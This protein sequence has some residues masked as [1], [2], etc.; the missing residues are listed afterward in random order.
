MG[1]GTETEGTT[2]DVF[3]SYTRAE[4]ADARRLIA[5]LEQ[6]GFSVWWDGML[7][8][9]TVFTRTTEQALDQAKAVVV[10]WS[11]KSVHS[12]WVRDEAQAGRETGRLVPVSFDGTLPPLGFRQFQSVDLSRWTGKP[13]APEF[14]NVRDSIA[15]LAGGGA[16][17]DSVPPASFYR[18]ASAASSGTTR[19]WM[20]AVA[21]VLLAIAGLYLAWNRLAV[22]PEDEN[23][24]AILRFANLSG[25]EEQAYFSTGLSEEMR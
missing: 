20:L 25:E 17:V 2:P 14:R 19:R 24:I 11:A 16:A 23:S 7:Q 21:T 18:S 22:T 1:T 9:G 15:R 8:A 12:N 3:V 6:A 5:A 10:L 4:E 13:D